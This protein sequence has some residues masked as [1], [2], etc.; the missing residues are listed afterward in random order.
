MSTAFSQKVFS[1]KLAQ[2]CEKMRERGAHDTRFHLLPD[3]VSAMVMIGSPAGVVSPAGVA[4]FLVYP[5]NGDTTNYTFIRVF[6]V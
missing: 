2:L 5:E 4:S 6:Q 1:E 3:G